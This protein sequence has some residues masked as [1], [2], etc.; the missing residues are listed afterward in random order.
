MRRNEVLF[1]KCFDSATDGRARYTA[2]TAF[3]DPMTPADAPPRES[4]ETRTIAFFAP[5]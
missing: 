1:L 5:E 3:D 2:H 4:I